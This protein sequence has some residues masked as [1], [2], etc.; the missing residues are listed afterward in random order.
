[1]RYRI[2]LAIEIAFAVVAVLAL[3][4]ISTGRNKARVA[5]PVASI[6]PETVT[7]V[8]SLVCLPAKATPPPAGGQCAY[9]LRVDTGT[10]YA[11][12]DEKVK[13][14][15]F[16]NGQR[17]RVTGHFTAHTTSDYQDVGVIVIST[18]VKLPAR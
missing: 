17:V 16:D 1:M 18:L 10:Y 5:G 3:V 14:P 7:K 6:A 4:F 8:G 15:N 13:T 9:G 12:L 11:L 2:R